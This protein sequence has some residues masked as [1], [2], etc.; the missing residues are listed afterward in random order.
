[1]YKALQSTECSEHFWKLTCRKKC[2]RLWREAHFEVKSAK[3]WRER[4]TF[5]RSDVVLRGR[6]KGLCTWSKVNKIWGFCSTFKNNGTRGTFEETLQRCFRVAGAVQERHE[7]DMLG[8]QGADFLRGVAFLEH[9]IFRFAKM[10]C[11]TDAKLRMTWHHYFVAAQHFRQMEWKNRKMHWHEAVGS[12]LNFPC[13]YKYNYNYFTPAL[14]HKYKDKFTSSHYT[15]LHDATL[16]YTTLTTTTATTTTTLL[17]TTYSTLHCATLHCT[18]LQR[19]TYSTL[20][21]LHDISF[22]YTH[23]T[24]PQLQLQLQLR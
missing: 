1:M 22:H 20:Y 2:T 9:R 14:Q 17:Y 23:Y 3:K 15:T 12:A 18:T 11:M 10:I 16:H 8:G 24:T 13:L 19:T 4:S 7:L 6:C 21:T 5:G